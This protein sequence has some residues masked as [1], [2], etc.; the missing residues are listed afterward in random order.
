M[1]KNLVQALMNDRPHEW[2]AILENELKIRVVHA[3]DLASLKYDQIESPM[4][5]PI[6]QQC[7]GSQDAE[8]EAILRAHRWAPDV[9]IYSDAKFVVRR[10]QEYRRTQSTIGRQV[11]FLRKTP[12]LRGAV[13]QRAHRLSVQGRRTLVNRELGE[14]PE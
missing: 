3:G 12:D 4:H 1:M 2:L 6:V 7:R 9:L 5:E 10:L 11:R 14:R 8:Y 13:Y